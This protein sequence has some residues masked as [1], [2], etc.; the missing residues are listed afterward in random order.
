MREKQKP[1]LVQYY[2]LQGS[3]Y[4]PIVKKRELNNTNN[5]IVQC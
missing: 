5:M 1:F 2:I 3:S 4:Y